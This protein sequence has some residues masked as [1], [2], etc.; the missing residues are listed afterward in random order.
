M[1][2]YQHR[3]LIFGSPTLYFFL[4][5]LRVPDFQKNPHQW[6]APPSQSQLPHS[7]GCR[8][9]V[10]APPMSSHVS[11][12][13]RAF[14]AQCRLLTMRPFL[15]GSGTPTRNAAVLRSE[16]RERFLTARVDID[17]IK[18]RESALPGLPAVFFCVSASFVSLASDSVV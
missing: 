17:G 2:P 1:C 8:M 4:L 11:I 6:R 7:V 16:D 18:M 14:S 12:L 3:S 13:P 5:E 15:Q 10:R 9:S